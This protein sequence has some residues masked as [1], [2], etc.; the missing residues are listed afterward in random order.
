VK[1]GETGEWD[2]PE[3]HEIGLQITEKIAQMLPYTPPT[4]AEDDWDAAVKNFISELTAVE[5]NGTWTIGRFE[6]GGAQA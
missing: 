1:A 5:V 6:R 2:T 3:L 4:D